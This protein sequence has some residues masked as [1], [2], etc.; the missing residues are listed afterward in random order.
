MARAKQA[1]L[2]TEVMCN[3]YPPSMM[4]SSYRPCT[5]RSDPMCYLFRICI[6]KVPLL[7]LS[8][9]RVLHL[10][11]FCAPRAR[12]RVL[13]AIETVWLGAR[14]PEWFSVWWLSQTH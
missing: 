2:Y 10:A 1:K 7:F 4:R 8:G 14:D 12:A 13:R 5:Y 6:S 3:I 9:I 11:G